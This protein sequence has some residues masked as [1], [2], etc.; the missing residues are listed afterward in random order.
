MPLSVALRTSFC[1]TE[2]A[3]AE[4]SDAPVRLDRDRIALV[5]P[6]KRLQQTIAGADPAVRRRV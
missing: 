6:A 3:V 5:V 1:L 4:R 2:A